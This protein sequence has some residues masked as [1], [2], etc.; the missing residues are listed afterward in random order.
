MEKIKKVLLF[1]ILASLLYSC[2]GASE[3]SKVLR[4]EK[5]KTTDEFLVKKREPLTL[6]P[7][8]NELPEPGSITNSKNDNRDQ[9]DKI[10]NIPEEKI[11]KKK[12]SS[13]IEQSIINEIRK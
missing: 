4:N 3:V 10:L 7:E 11:V 13:S 8:Y 12:Q 5:I 6:P 1:Y 9:I 2:G